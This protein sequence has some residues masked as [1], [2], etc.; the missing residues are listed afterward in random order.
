ME[1]DGPVVRGVADE[2]SKLAQ[3][4]DS[5]VLSEEEFNREKAFLLDRGGSHGPGPTASTSMER[6]VTQINYQQWTGR[7]VSLI[8]DGA[9]RAFLDV[10]AAA[11]ERAG[12]PI[13]ERSYADMKLT[14]ESRGISW[15]SWSGDVTTVLITP[16][17]GGSRATFTSKGKPSGPLRVQ[18]RVNATTWVGRILPGFGHL[19]KG[20]LDSRESAPLEGWYPDPGESSMLRWWDG[21]GWTEDTRPDPDQHG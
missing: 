13:T 12:Y 7:A 6:P 20:D 10:I 11:V 4:R 21:G 2:L 14:F 1:R 15:T 17:E 19:W 3:L 8:S 18:M 16:L 9:P 5:G